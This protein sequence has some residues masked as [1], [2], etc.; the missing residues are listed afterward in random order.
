MADLVVNTWLQDAVEQHV[1]SSAEEQVEAWVKEKHPDARVS[2]CLDADIYA[3]TITWEAVERDAY[4][5]WGVSLPVTCTHLD[6]A[7]AL[8]L[9]LDGAPVP[10]NL[11][12]WSTK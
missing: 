7:E 8:R 10:L 1:I 4:G 5:G 9:F 6:P 11:P 2:V 3:V 12:P